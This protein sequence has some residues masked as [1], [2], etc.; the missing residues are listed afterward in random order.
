MFP[1]Q[2][3]AWR[4]S[5]VPTGVVSWTFTTVMEMMTVGIGLMNLIAV[6]YLQQGPADSDQMALLCC[7]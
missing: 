5:S 2:H 6:S 3:V 1:Q 7:F 4:N